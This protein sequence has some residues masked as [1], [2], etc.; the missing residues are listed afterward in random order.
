MGQIE[1]GSIKNLFVQIVAFAVMG[2]IL[3]PLFDLVVCNFFTHTEFVYSVSSHIV[4]PILFGVV[5]GLVFWLL[6]K[7][8]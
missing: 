3:Y 2:I 7:R 6:D 8:K 1:K 5:M 4:E